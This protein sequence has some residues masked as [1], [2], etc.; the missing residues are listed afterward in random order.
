[1]M[2]M[3]PTSLACCLVHVNLSLELPSIQN[4]LVPFLDLAPKK[5]EAC[6]EGVAHAS[7]RCCTPV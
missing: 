1:M 5:H 4:L 7:G 2:M 6:V 3:Q